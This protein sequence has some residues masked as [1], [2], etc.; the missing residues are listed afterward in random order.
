VAFGGVQGIHRGACG[1]QV[2]IEQLG[3]R[4]GLSVLALARPTTF[5]PQTI[6]LCG[7]SWAK[8]VRRAGAA[9]RAWVL[10]RS[11]GPARPVSASWP[12]EPVIPGGTALSWR[13]LSSAGAD[14]GR[15]GY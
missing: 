11:S 5:M 14:L 3:Q 2:V 7:P 1:I 12:A 8:L 6:D 9:D 4:R 13:H 10:R 15:A